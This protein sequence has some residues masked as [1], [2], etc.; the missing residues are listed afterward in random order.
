MGTPPEDISTPAGTARPATAA[1]LA[2][3]RTQA[4]LLW[5][6][7]LLSIAYSAVEIA[8]ALQGEYA[9]DA[10]DIIWVF[11]FAILVAF[12][13]SNDARL[14][15]LDEPYE[16]SWLVF[17]L[18]PVLLPHHLYRS[19]GTQ[20]LVTFLGFVAIQL[21]PFLSGLVVRSWF[22]HAGDGMIAGLL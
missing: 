20:G 5:G 21:A 18:W 17:L 7:V 15:A 12:W 16:F 10:A 6:L 13:T 8:L 19:R 2:I 14:R 9:S 3:V 1:T 22:G 4:R 11:C